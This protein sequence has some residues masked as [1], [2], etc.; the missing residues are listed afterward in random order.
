MRVVQPDGRYAGA[1]AAQHE[2]RADVFFSDGH[3]EYRAI[4]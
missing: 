4:R 3:Y 1:A 2:Q